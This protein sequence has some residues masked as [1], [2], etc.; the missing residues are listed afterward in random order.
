MEL[1]PQDMVSCDISNKGCNGGWLDNAW[2][3]LESDG[4]V[5]EECI[6]YTSGDD[7]RQ[8]KC[9]KFC[10]KKKKNYKKYKVLPKSSK[11]LMCTSDIKN[12]ILNNG[13][14][15]TGF[16]VY[17]DFMHYKGGVYEY[18][19]GK[20]LGGHAV[21][22]IGWG[23]EGEKEFWIAE[24]SWGSNWGENGFFRIKIGD[25]FFGENTYAGKANT[26]LT[27]WWPFW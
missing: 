12:E 22:I 14:V 26:I 18:V 3:F 16:I 9:L 2:R 15:Q 5:A 25:C 4:I 19:S 10:T 1:S 6:P 11:P 8:P 24:N 20:Q 7:E 21:K 17:E 23:K 13:P 27:S